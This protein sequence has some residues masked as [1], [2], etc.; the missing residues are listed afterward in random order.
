MPARVPDSLRNRNWLD[1]EWPF[2]IKERFD[3]GVTKFEILA[4]GCLV[5]TLP[6]REAAEEWV[7]KT[8]PVSIAIWVAEHRSLH[9]V[10]VTIDGGRAGRLARIPPEL[11]ATYDGLLVRAISN[12]VTLKS[13]KACAA[14]PNEIAVFVHIR[15][16]PGAR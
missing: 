12:A 3:C 10:E 7:E 5:A 13:A 2:E 11:W 16:R 9:P 14:F 6:L 8:K 4:D 15:R 1:F